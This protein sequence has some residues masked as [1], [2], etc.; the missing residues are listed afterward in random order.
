MLY[1]RSASGTFHALLFNQ[2]APSQL[3]QAINRITS[4]ETNVASVS[5]RVDTINTVATQ[6]KKTGDDLLAANQALTSKIQS[7][8]SRVQVGTFD[9]EFGWCTGS[10]DRYI[11]R[12]ITFP[13]TFVNSPTVTASLSVIDGYQSADDNFVRVYAIVQTVSTRG[14]T[15]TLRAGAVK[16]LWL[17]SVSWTAVS[18]DVLA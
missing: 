1:G 13:T 11:N 7:R 4:L 14:F 3:T 5:T 15:I 2:P 18:N 9:V 16:C 10:W 8:A 12:T 17:L 6:A